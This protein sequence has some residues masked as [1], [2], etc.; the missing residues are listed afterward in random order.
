M[1]WSLDRRTCEQIISFDKAGITRSG[2][3]TTPED[4]FKR[5]AAQQQIYNRIGFNVIQDK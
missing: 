3:E 1:I 2:T 5:T 4:G